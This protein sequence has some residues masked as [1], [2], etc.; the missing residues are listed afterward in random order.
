MGRFRSNTQISIADL[1]KI[2]ALNNILTGYRLDGKSKKFQISSSNSNEIVK[3]A[4]S[5][6]GGSV[7]E[8][9]T[10]Y[11][12]CSLLEACGISVQRTSLVVCNDEVVVVCNVEYEIVPLKS[13]KSRFIK[14]KLVY[15]LDY[16]MQLAEAREPK[17]NLEEFKRHLLQRLIYDYH[18]RNVDLHPGNIGFYR[19]SEGVFQPSYIYDM[20]GSLF[21][22]RVRDKDYEKYWR[23]TNLKIKFGKEFHNIVEFAKECGLLREYIES[24]AKLMDASM[25]FDYDKIPAEFK[26]EVEKEL[27]QVVESCKSFMEDSV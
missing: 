13:I 8:Q 2:D 19:D 6:R 27:Y 21:T 10:E 4:K 25:E 1:P 24:T 14:D 9:V 5:T 26:Y 12:C 3:F 18:L 20:G 22:H 16:F 23:K 11:V 17:I 15:D 7:N